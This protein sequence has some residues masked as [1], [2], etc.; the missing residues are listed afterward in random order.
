MNSKMDSK[1]HIEYK[2]EDDK[3]NI[4]QEKTDK[5]YFEEHTSIK[6][7]TIE[8]NEYFEEDVKIENKYSL[9][10]KYKCDECDYSSN[11][12]H[13]LTNHVASVHKK[14]VHFSCSLCEYKS[15]HKKSVK[16]H[17][18]R[19]H[20]GLSE[21]ILKTDCGKCKK[22]EIHDRCEEAN[23][24]EKS[25]RKCKGGKLKCAEC[26]Y[27]SDRKQ[28]FNEHVASQH[29]NFVRFSCS[30]CDYRSFYKVS[31]KVHI[32]SR[33]KGLIGKILNIDCEKCQKD[34]IHKKC[35]SANKKRR[36]IGVTPDKN[37]AKKQQRKFKGGKFQCTECDYSSDRKLSLNDHVGCV[38]NG[39]VN[40]QCSLCEYRSN[41]RRYMRSHIRVHHKGMDAKIITI[42]CRNCQEGRS[43]K[44]CQKENDPKNSEI[45]GEKK[46]ECTQCYFRSF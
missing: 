42:G 9:D 30:L 4:K 5:E 7:E 37:V 10:Q 12:Q 19:I 31:L 24:K 40:Y 45:M 17:M 8:Y 2:V 20:R 44:K 32:N 46:Y 34:E 26:D 27:S 22:N 6:T 43:H 25:G 36:S 28:H 39:V 41:P 21:T 1:E 11:I 29:H 3:K 33:H 14:V 15:F 38:H 18:Q 35:E 16:K 13:N 23:P